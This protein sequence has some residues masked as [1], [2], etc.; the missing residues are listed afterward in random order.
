MSEYKYI[1]TSDGE[2]YHW[3]Y[4]K[5]EKLPGGGYRYYYKD[6]DFDDA[7]IKYDRAKRDYE[8]ARNHSSK[9]DSFISY[10]QAQLDKE[11]NGNIQATNENKHLQGW[12]ESGREAAERQAEAY[13]QYKRSK[14]TYDRARDVY[15]KSKVHNVADFLTKA[16]AT[17]NK[18][19]KW[20]SGLFS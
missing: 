14:N 6:T 18:A 17:I 3:K 19:K 10:Y 20:L 7:K 13:Q 4:I 5:R 8:H 1:I 9:I 15:R 11:N 16:S 2:L 12:K